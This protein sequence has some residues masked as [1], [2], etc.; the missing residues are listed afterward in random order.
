MRSTVIILALFTAAALAQAAPAAEQTV[1]LKVDNMT[2]VLCAPTVKKSLERVA[3][4]AKVEVNSDRGTAIV[5]FDDAKAD[6]GALVKAT[7]EAGYP[8]R[9]VP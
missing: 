1:T 4:V 7:T 6:V 8:S 3:G 9:H 5:T 2:C